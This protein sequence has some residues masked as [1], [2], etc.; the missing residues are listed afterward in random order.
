LLPAR[1]GVFEK[2]RMRADV[3]SEAGLCAQ[4]LVRAML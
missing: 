3:K 1:R 4:S 2:D